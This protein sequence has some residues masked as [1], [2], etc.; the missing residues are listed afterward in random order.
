MSKHKAR[1]SISKI[2]VNNST[3]TDE[4][5]ICNR[6]NDYFCDVGKN[7]ASSINCQ[8]HD[9][10]KYCHLPN[11]NS[12]FCPPA[13][14]AEILKII[15][16]FRNNKSPGPDNIAP[17]LIKLISADII[18]PLLYIFNLSFSS[19]QV[20]QSLKIAKVIP[21]Y[22]KGGKDIPGNYRPISLLSIFD[23]ILEKLMFNR[24]Y[25]FLVQ[26]DILYKYQFGFRKGYSTSL[27]LVEL[28]DTIYTHCDNRD[29]VIG[30]FFDLQKAFDTVDHSI[31]LH[32]MN[33]CGIRGIVLKWFRNYLSNRKQFVS[34]GNS[35]S[36]LQNVTCGVPQGSVLGPLLFLLY[37]NDIEN[38]VRNATVKLFADD[39]NL[40][41]H[42]KTLSEAFD[43]ANDAVNL[44]QDWF[45][46]NKLSLNIEK[47]CY[48]VFRCDDAVTS[49]CVIKLGNTNLT[50]VNCTKYLGIVID[51]DLSWKNHIDYL[52]KKLLKFTGIFYKLRSRVRPHVLKMLYFNFVYP[53]LLYGI[54]V[55]ANSCKSH[56]EKLTVLNNK[57]LRIVQNCSIRTRIVDLYRQYLTLPLPL[58]H[59]YNVLIFVH[60]CLYNSH[61]LPS[62]LSDYFQPNSAI[63]VYTTRSIDK[64]HLYSV[65]SSLGLKCIKFKGS[66]M[67]NSLPRS[68]SDICS[69]AVFKKHLKCYLLQSM[70]T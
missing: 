32:K 12:M 65:N 44:L 3:Y 34:I 51:S 64:L 23:K 38:C 26:N 66:L 60:K 50:P 40:F 37:I 49:T 35:K 70:L 6:L 24:I 2:T 4:K 5:D 69:H 25:S 39:T 42:G 20:P 61:M 55:Y 9:F 52:Y 33:N 19:G 27:A 21:L 41:V 15:L 62:V 36:D 13:T 22:K 1:T 10:T 68:I 58:L 47:S 54:E 57:L 17:K 11:N 63:H 43:K 30:M 18:E 48:T 59:Q 7:L 16:S 29:T 31:L 53:Q 45:V 67:W 46:V 14:G 56:L 8:P 28:V